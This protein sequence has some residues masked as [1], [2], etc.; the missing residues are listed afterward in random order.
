[1]R[2]AVSVELARHEGAVPKLVEAVVCAVGY[3][4][5]HPLFQRLLTWEPQVVLPSLTT[6]AQPVLRGAIELLDPVV[7]AGR[8]AGEL[9]PG[10]DPAVL[11]ECTARLALSLMVT[12]SLA[13]DADDPDA[14]RHFVA[15]LFDLRCS[16]HSVPGDG[17]SPGGRSPIPSPPRSPRKSSAPGPTLATKPVTRKRRSAPS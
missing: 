14:L 4:R 1:M 3:A 6:G 15:Q 8:A 7:D 12:P 10:V 11:A 5:R 9:P 17:R 16:S 13:V 2:R